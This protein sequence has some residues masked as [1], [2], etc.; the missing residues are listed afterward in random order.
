MHARIDSSAGRL[1]PDRKLGLLAGADL[2]AA[3]TDSGEAIVAWGGEN[4]I[5][6]QSCDCSTVAGPASF[7]ASLG[8]LAG[9]FRRAIRLTSFADPHGKLGLDPG[10]GQGGRSAM[11]L[12]L[13]GHDQRPV[14][15]WRQLIN[16]VMVARIATG[17]SFQARHDISVTGLDT[18][19][20]DLISGPN[21][22]L[23]ALSSTVSGRAS[24]PP[25]AGLMSECAATGLAFRAPER[26]SSTAATATGPVAAFDPSNDVAVAAW[27]DTARGGEIAVA[28][29]STGC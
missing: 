3:L 27:I 29:R 1:G 18:Q 10:F 22:E 4:D 23:L 26:L 6:Y 2:E 7:R 15:G 16:G 14:V 19:L 5:Y 21:G 24:S 8:N 13:R 28:H 25:A 17:S 20:D 9:R 11:W 12:V